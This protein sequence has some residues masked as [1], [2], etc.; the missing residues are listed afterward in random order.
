MRT[1][2]SFLG[3]VALVAIAVFGAALPSAAIDLDSAKAQG[4]VGEQTDGYV[5]AVAASAPADVQAL[6][7]DVNAKRRAAYQEIAQKNGTKVD[8][9]GVLAA[10]KLI[11]RAPPGA[12]IRDKGQWYQKK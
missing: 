4:I 11:G 5:A 1:R 3:F 12:W 8:D 2:R 10:Q 7:A 6:V 9:V